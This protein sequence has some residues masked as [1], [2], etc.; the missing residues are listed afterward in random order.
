MGIA[1]NRGGAGEALAAAYLEL[2]GCEVLER[3]TKIAG[4]EV[5][6]MVRDD[7]TL[8]LVEVK[9]RGRA[10]YGGA[11]SSITGKQ[12]ERL[13]RAATVAAAKGAAVRVDVVAIE[14]NQ[15]GAVVRH[16]R[17]ALSE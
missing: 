2:A 4:I 5:D 10:D 15:D 7:R 14:R 8:V 11:A 6:L 17:N 13:L 3:N 1:R 9:F 12:R 16:Y